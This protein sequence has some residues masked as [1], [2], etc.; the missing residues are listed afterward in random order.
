[1]AVGVLEVQAAAAVAVVDG[2]A[3]GPGR[4]GPVGQVSLA[5][6]VEGSV[7][8]GLADQERVVL[9]R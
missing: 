5:E 2:L 6:T 9:R 7:E 4:I 1:M 3:L 8:L